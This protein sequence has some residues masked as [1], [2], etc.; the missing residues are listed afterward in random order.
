[1]VSQ[2]KYHCIGIS[3]SNITRSL[4]YYMHITT[5]LQSPPLPPP[6]PPT[7]THTHTETTIQLSVCSKVF[8]LCHF[9]SYMGRKISVCIATYVHAVLCLSTVSIMQSCALSSLEFLQSV[10]WSAT[11]EPHADGIQATIFDVVRNPSIY[12]KQNI[13]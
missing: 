11:A 6:P 4:T 12:T 1:M 10:H 13:A 5:C 2:T 7:H 9:L 3:N 8:D